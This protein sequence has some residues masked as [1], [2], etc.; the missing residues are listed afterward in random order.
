MLRTEMQLE[1]PRSG[2]ITVHTDMARPGPARPGGRRVPVIIMTR[3]RQE[4]EAATECTRALAPR[5][6]Q[7]IGAR[8]QSFSVP[9]AAA[10]LSGGSV[11]VARDPVARP[12]G[13]VHWQRP[14][15]CASAR[16]LC[17]TTQV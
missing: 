16:C 13:D 3:T 12:L 11:A 4:A 2:M 1:A 10:P 15:L 14:G 9:V 5:L 17:Q 7:P 8:F 6:Q